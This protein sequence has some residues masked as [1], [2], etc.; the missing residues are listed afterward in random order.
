[1]GFKFF[2]LI[3]CI[4]PAGMPASGR[5]GTSP[6]ALC[7]S[8]FEKGFLRVAQGLKVGRR[9]LGMSM[10]GGHCWGS[11]LRQAGEIVGTGVV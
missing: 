3:L 9:R 11:P 5:A 8:M 7:F 1:M 4:S 6:V 10:L 2:L